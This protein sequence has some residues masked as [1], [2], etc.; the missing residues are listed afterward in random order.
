MFLLW[1]RQLPHCGDQTP[2]SV[3]P[4]TEGR[5]SPTVTPGFPPSS[6]I[7]LSFAWFYIFFFA[8]QVL[9]YGLSWCSAWTSVCLK[10]HSWCI[11]RERCTPR[12]PTSPPSCSSVSV[13]NTLSRLVIAFLPRSK[14][15]LVSWLQSPSAVIL[16][17][18]KIKSVSA[19]IV[20]PS[21]CHEVMGQDAM[22]FMFW[23]LS[24]KPVFSLSSF[25]F[26]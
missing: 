15:L 14:Y 20:A 10:V 5:F 25:T 11:H 17:L 2:A 16:E 23:M 21:I 24:F 22:I 9:L 18:P 12:L 4:P 19:S 13:F 6:F 1:L 7:L 26:I 3:L 8:G